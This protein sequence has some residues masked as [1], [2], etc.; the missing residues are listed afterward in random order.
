[1]NDAAALEPLVAAAF[2]A[3]G[4]LARERSDY[5]VRD[6][7]VTMAMAVGKAIA[8][9][10]TV[11][12][13]A[14]TGVGKTYAY[15]VPLILSG[16]RALV[17]TATKGLQDQLFS[18]DL[19]RV[20]L[21]LGMALDVALL[22]GRESYL[23]LH[24]MKTARQHAHGAHQVTL[25]S[26]AM[27]ERWAQA[28]RTGDLGEVEG[29]G[30]GAPVLPLVSSTRD[31]CLGSSC[32][33]F[34]ACHVVR[35]RR[36]A[37][38]ADIVVVNH[39]LYFADQALRETGMAELLPSVDVVVFDEAHHLVDIGVQFLGTTLSTAQ[40]LDVARDLLALGL[41]HARGL[42]PWSEL[43]AG[44]DHAARDLRL[45][46]PRALQGRGAWP[47]QNGAFSQALMHL[48]Q[49]AHACQPALTACASL[50]PALALLQTR[51][52]SVATLAEGYLEDVPSERVR[53]VDITT[54]HARLQESPLDIAQALN[55]QRERAPK[56]WVF[57]SATLGEDDALSWFS[58]PTG[59][60]HDSAVQTLR[61]PSPFDHAAQSR[62]WVCAQAP[63]P[64][65]PAHSAY[66]GTMA[67]R[68][69]TVLQGRTI[70]LTTTIRAMQ[71]IAEVLRAALQQV[72]APIRVMV[73]GEAPKRELLDRLRHEQPGTVLVATQSFWEGVD[74]VGDALQCV[75]I[76]K[77]PF[78]PPDDPLIEARA[79]R[80]EARGDNPFTVCF[81]AEAAIALKQGSGRLIRSETDRGLLVVADPRMATMGYGKRLKRALPPMSEV[82][83]E[84]S[85]LAWLQQLSGE[86]RA[87]Q[88]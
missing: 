16:R 8:D 51:M 14:A 21:A 45:A 39:H 85:A 70:I 43:A 32:D 30:E 46:L 81:V 65:D 57:T 73:Q 68:C 66:V 67:A 40:V 10:S 49:A 59:L 79:R 88:S 6:A 62:L 7:Q 86:H 64:S 22:K 2:A 12:V 83:D 25:R 75:I 42:Q 26:L 61:L 15:L 48:A 1:M 11:V 17:S 76:D 31:N 53:W 74:V 38:A 5:R 78:P 77:L 3:H 20:R 60:K 58:E 23:C 47:T 35:A 55:A 18:R 52:G 84:A 36:E 33:D 71:K 44:V 27:I 69:V 28:T 50:D 4:P 41:Q 56:A 87:H 29:L 37:M 72:D 34:H 54:Q 80:V 82:G 24:R 19:P 13:E 9:Q 63:R